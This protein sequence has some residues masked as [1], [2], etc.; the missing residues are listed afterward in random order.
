MDAQAFY[1]LKISAHRFL[2]NAIGV[3]ENIDVDI[4]ITGL[5]A[6]SDGSDV[7]QLDDDNLDDNRMMPEEVAG[8]VDVIYE[9][10]EDTTTC[11]SSNK[12]QRIG[13]SK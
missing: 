11:E 1:G 3:A 10:L 6:G 8:E 13:L 7:E 4:V 2:R 5:P 9:E 12:K